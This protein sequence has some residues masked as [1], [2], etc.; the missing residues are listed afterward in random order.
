MIIITDS[1]NA[2]N[3]TTNF[4]SIRSVLEHSPQQSKLRFLRERTLLIGWFSRNGLF[5]KL[6]MTRSGS[7]FL[8]RVSTLS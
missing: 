7:N 1:Y 5:Y 2:D 6:I 4:Q 8:S 3:S